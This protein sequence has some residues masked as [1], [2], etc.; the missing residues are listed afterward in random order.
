MGDE[1]NVV[2]D[3]S[4]NGFLLPPL[5]LQPLVENSVQHGLAKSDVSGTL[6][7]R[8]RRTQ[9]AHEIIISDNGTG[10]DVRSYLAQEGKTCVGI[11]NVRKRLWSLCAA[12][13]EI[14]SELGRGTKVVIRI[15]LN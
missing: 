1:L 7:I 6:V 9:T 4:D 8:T 5:T 13:L 12:T 11:E 10:F 3:I 14:S 15:P 2:Y